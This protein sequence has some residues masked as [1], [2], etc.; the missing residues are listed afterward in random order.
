[1]SC[2][3]IAK[4]QR[5][6]AILAVSLLSTYGSLGQTSNDADLPNYTI[7]VVRDGDSWYFDSSVRLA[8]EELS[9]MADDRYSFS[10]IDDYNAGYDVERV[11][12]YLRETLVDDEIDLVFA[13][14]I[15][16]TERAA[17]YSDA[18]RV[19]PIIGGALQFSD[20]RGQP[21]SSEGTSRLANYTFITSP[22]R[23]LADLELL[24]SLSNSSR[25][26]ALV[27]EIALPEMKDLPEAKALIEA[28]LGLV[29]DVVPGG[30]SAVELMDRIPADAEAAYVTI[31]PRMDDA[32]RSELYRALTQRK[33]ATV[34]MNG[35]ND[36]TLGALAGLATDERQAIARRTALNIHQ[37]FQGVRTTSLPVYLPV[38]DRL[39]INMKTAEALDWSPD[40]D[41]A[42][43][44]EF[45]GGDREL[46]AESMN[47]LKAMDAGSQRNIDVTISREDQAAAEFDVEITRSSLRPKLEGVGS[48]GRQHTWDRISPFTTPDYSHQESVGM[49]VTKILFSGEVWSGLRAQKQVAEASRFTTLSSELDSIGA[50]ASAYFDYLTAQSLNEIER[51]NLRLTENNYQLAQLRIEIGAAEP[52]ESYRWEQNRARNRATLIQRESDRGNALVAFNIR[53]GAARDA[54]WDFEDVQIGDTELYF[55]D[56]VLDPLLEN[57]NDFKD[58][59]KF[60]QLYAIENSPELFAFDL[61]L[62]GQGILLRQS[63]RRFTPDISAFADYAHVFQGSEFFDTDSENQASAGI[64]FSVPVFESGQRRAEFFK[65]QAIVR[66]LAAQREKA[67]QLIEQRGIAAYYGISAAHPNMRLSRVSELA[68]EKNYESIQ[69]KYSLGAATIL[70]LLD[71]QQALL[72]QKQQSAVAGYDYLKTIHEVQRAMA[73]FEFQKSPEEKR[74][75]AQVLRQFLSVGESAFGEDGTKPIQQ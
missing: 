70:D 27:D 11:D 16:A 59:G 58:F 46:G 45:V 2:P 18:I 43:A 53:I 50:A 13:A 24:K 20:S 34:T 52:S 62:A 32:E 6:F 41:T 22:R 73:W 65:N 51:E 30:A 38:F 48:Y 64:Q 29:V 75:W 39:V 3:T 8:L 37:I 54:L 71:A 68:A 33:I 72:T 74:A 5:G 14:G 4:N 15:V 60:V 44:A 26:Y 10:V 19:K 56:D 28:A 49:Q 55:M 7:A 31:L 61:Q 69:E 12:R 9:A 42:L 25:V 57:A 36:I 66:G 21:I 17:N 47:L 67:K 40:Y 23:V 63:K 35:H 1:M